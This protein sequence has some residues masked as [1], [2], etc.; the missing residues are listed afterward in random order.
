G[1]VLPAA[2]GLTVIGFAFRAGGAPKIQ[3]ALAFVTMHLA[4]GAGFLFGR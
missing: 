3:V 2:Y 1:L 4:W